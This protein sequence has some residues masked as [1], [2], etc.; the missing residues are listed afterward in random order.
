MKNRNLIDSFNNAINGIICAIKSERNMKIHICTAIVVFIM[1]IFFDLTKAEFLIVC[2]SVAMVIVSELFNT[3]IEEL[4]NMITTG[5]HPKVKIIKD[6]SA[7]AVLVSAFFAVIVGYFVFFEHVST[8]LES[9]VERIRQYPMHITIIA[10]IV[11]V[12]V[13]LVLKAVTGKG[14]P[15][16][17]GLPSGHAAI[18]SAITTAVALWS[19]N[20]KITLLCIV[21][22]LLVIQSRL[23]AKIHNFIE[24]FIGAVIGFLITLLLFQTFL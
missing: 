14:T 4:V 10:L 13:V 1:S 11:T 5:Y 17:G 9:G 15:L 19:I 16:R 24:V 8:G 12:S 6:V 21:L 18:A 20:S 23:E 3:A 7:G 22:S 2:I